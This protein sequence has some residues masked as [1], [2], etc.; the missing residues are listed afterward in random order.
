LGQGTG[1]SAGALH[2]RPLLSVITVPDGF[3][4]RFDHVA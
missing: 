3:G 2:E 4:R 1:H